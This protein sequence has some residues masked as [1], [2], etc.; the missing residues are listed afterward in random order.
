MFTDR[1]E[2]H[3]NTM[4]KITTYLSHTH[5]TYLYCHVDVIIQ[6]MY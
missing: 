2:V 6:Q 3:N 1:L 5:T 4:V